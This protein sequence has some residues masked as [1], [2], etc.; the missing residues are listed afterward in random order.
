[1]NPF[2]HVAKLRWAV[3]GYFVSFAF[4]A[5]VALRV[6]FSKDY[7]LLFLSALSG[8]CIG[9][10][11]VFFFSL[12]G[13]RPGQLRFQLIGGIAFDVLCNLAAARL[14]QSAAEEAPR[15]ALVALANLGL[16]VAATSLGLLVARGLR[17][18]NYLVMAA[19]VGA[20]T[21]IFSVYAGPSK[22]MLGSEAFP[23]MSYQ[24]GIIGQGGINPCVGA[25][26]FVFLA[27]YFYGARRFGLDDR[28]TLIAMIIAFTLG[29]PALVLRPGGIPALPFM[30]A[31]LLAVHGRELKLQMRAG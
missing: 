14:G 13:D 23:Y 24:W 10:V 4:F 26:D 3:L 11:I 29:Y 8:A 21:D 9:I 15:L 19:V 28:K 30:S 20:V 27:L 2:S 12:G 6:P 1:M 31:M 7:L 18:P 25:G 22:Q 5:V 17:R 16:L